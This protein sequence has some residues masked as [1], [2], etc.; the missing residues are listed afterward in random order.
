MRA[1]DSHKLEW[2]CCI[3]VVIILTTE[4]DNHRGG[5]APHPRN[6]FGEC[7]GQNPSPLWYLSLW[8]LYIC[9]TTPARIAKQLYLHSHSHLEKI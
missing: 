3:N 5:E 2:S 1:Q 8:L 4:I 7:E 9:A 6:F